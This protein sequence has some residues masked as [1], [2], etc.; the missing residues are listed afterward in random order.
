MLLPTERL[1]LRHW[2]RGKM[3]NTKWLLY[4]DLAR[5]A[6]VL[7]MMSPLLLT[8]QTKV[9]NKQIQCEKQLCLWPSILCYDHLSSAILCYIWPSI[10]CY[11]HLSSAMTIY[12][13]LSSPIYDHLSS[14]ILCYDHLSS[15]PMLQSVTASDWH[16]DFRRPTSGNFICHQTSGHSQYGGATYLACLVLC[17]QDVPGRQISVHKRFACQVLHTWGYI[18]TESKEG[19]GSVRWYQLSWSDVK[20]KLL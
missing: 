18:L 1:E 4:P 17:N 3:A 11:D 15:A 10:L 13:L 8:M 12:P 16:S 9:Y 5:N 20:W 19:M 6:L 14:S 2:S 7:K